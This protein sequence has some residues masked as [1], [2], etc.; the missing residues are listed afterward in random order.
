MEMRKKHFSDNGLF[1]IDM[2]RVL[3]LVLSL[4]LQGMCSSLAAAPADSISAVD[5]VGDDPQT[6]DYTISPY[7]RN[8]RYIEDQRRRGSLPE[9][10][11]NCME[12]D[13]CFKRGRYFD[14]LKF[15]KRAMYDKN[16]HDS[17]TFIKRMEYRKILCYE[18]IGNISRL[19]YLVDQLYQSAVATDDAEF[20][21]VGKFYKGIID[22]YKGRKNEGYQQMSEAI[23]LMKKFDGYIK[24]DHLFLFYLSLL[25]LQQDDMKSEAALKTLLSVDSLLKD[26]KLGASFPFFSEDVRMREY[27]AYY[28]VTLHRLGR[29]DEAREYYN[30]YLSMGGVFSID[31]C[32]IEPYLVERGLYNDII[33]FGEI[34]LSQMH[35]NKDTVN[36]NAVAL[37]RLL[38]KAYAKKGDAE[39]V[40][41][42]FD[43]LE[44]TQDRLKTAV[45]LSAMDELSLNY[46]NYEEKLS[47]QQKKHADRIRYILVLAIVVALSI[48][49]FV[50]QAV[51]YN[52][53]I[54]RKN[55]SLVKT[56]D[57]LLEAK[58]RQY[59]K[60]Y[61][62]TH[63][64]EPAPEPAE[65]LDPAEVR[66]Q[67][68]ERIERNWFE[69]MSHDIVEQKLYLDPNLS[70]V[71]LL[72]KYKIPKNSFSQLFQKYAGT[73]YS[74]YINDLRLE[75]AAKMLKEHPNHTI[76]SVA[77]DCGISSVGTLYRLFSLKYGMTP[78]E[79]RFF[80]SVPKE[81]NPSADDDA[82]E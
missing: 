1:L 67:S 42:A 34:R 8:K 47:S 69:R 65:P 29:E 32:C 5:P 73:S 22:Y 6:S 14:A 16:V 64:P 48:A 9:H 10:R 11:L 74:K 17:T 50:Y 18:K 78:T 24:G 23:G 7:S 80:V 41:S 31:Y 3:V 40:V 19:A 4:T 77:V 49:V 63:E 30:K 59:E 66:A 70:R 52:R 55:L 20:L 54:T 28:T 46:E 26:G 37:Y 12:G 61:Q 51:R 81:E 82:K 68:N 21:A 60:A 72:A 13:L 35:A 58:N 57:E 15:Y 33:R 56:I 79:Y 2:H 44:E 27:Y 38:V 45:E 76:E 43:K 75:Y 25:K 36:F 71:F 53:V 39:R 62:E